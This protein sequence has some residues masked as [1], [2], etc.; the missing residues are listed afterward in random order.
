MRLRFR[1]TWCKQLR[2][3]SLSEQHESCCRWLSAQR[4]KLQLMVLGRSAPMQR[5]HVPARTGGA[6]HRWVAGGGYCSPMHL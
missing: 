2:G 3:R 1:C 5:L 6:S 4:L